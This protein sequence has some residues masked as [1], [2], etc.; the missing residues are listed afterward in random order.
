VVTEYG[1]APLK[2]QSLRQ[3]AHNLIQ[4]SH[5]DKKDELIEEFEKRFADKF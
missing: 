4:I 5:P 1:A 2:G 3:R